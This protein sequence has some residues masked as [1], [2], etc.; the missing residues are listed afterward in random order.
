MEFDGSD[1]DLDIFLQDSAELG[2][3]LQEVAE[4]G[5]DRWT[6]SVRWKTGFN[7]THIEAYVQAAEDAPVL[8]GIVLAWGYYARF[9]EHGTRF[10][11]PEHVMRDFIRDVEG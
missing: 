1:H 2:D 9:R 5:A 7:A 3:F 6:R 10:N 11:R 4:Q 8:E